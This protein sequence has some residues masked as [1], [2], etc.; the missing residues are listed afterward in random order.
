[1]W[2]SLILTA[3]S[4]LLLQALFV[5]VAGVL[6]PRGNVYLTII[7][8]CVLTTPIAVVSEMLFFSS[9]FT[10]EGRLFLVVIH[11]TLGGFLFHFMTLP[12]RSVTLR[13]LVELL[14]APGHALSLNAL[15]ARYSVRTMIE[16]R[17]TQLSAWRFLQLAPDGSITLIGKGLWFGRFVT[18]GRRLFGI[19]SA[20]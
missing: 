17:L 5:A 18:N 3:G 19:A 8:V 2:L 6:R 11:L 9:P 15:G 1:M 4:L 16:S 12:D 10:F 7:A 14:L 20:N 13:M